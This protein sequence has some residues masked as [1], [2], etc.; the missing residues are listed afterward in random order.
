MNLS[1][2]M[3][4]KIIYAAF[5]EFAEKGYDL[6]STNQIHRMAGVSKGVIFKIFG[7]KMELYYQVIESALDHMLAELEKIDFKAYSDPIER[8]V[9][10][11]MWKMDFARR[12]P[13]ATKVMLAAILSP[14]VA[15]ADRF[16]KKLT[17]LRKISIGVCF[18]DVSWDFISPE[19][20]REEVLEFMEISVLGFQ[21]KFTQQRPDLDSMEAIRTQSI[22]YLKTLLKGMERSNG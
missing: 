9:A 4:D 2:S 14:P 3:R 21:E 12:Y 13:E 20:S 1:D 7:S 10:I 18:E 16:R 8:I 5:D 19:Y 15:L 11:F 6:A 22:R 17:E